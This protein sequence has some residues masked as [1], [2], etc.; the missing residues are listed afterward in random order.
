MGPIASIMIAS[1][2][3]GNMIHALEARETEIDFSQLRGVNFYDAV[4]DSKEKSE[5]DNSNWCFSWTFTEFDKWL[6]L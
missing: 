5:S 2:L 6:W 1:L 4:F 3:L